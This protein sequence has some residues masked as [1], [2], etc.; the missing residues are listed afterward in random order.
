MSEENNRTVV[1]VIF[2]LTD[3][4]NDHLQAIY[5]DF[6]NN[7]LSVEGMASHYNLSIEDA[8]VLVTMAR[9]VHISRTE[10]N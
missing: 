7:F 3:S 4:T 5:L 6:W 10:G 9:N 8:R 2:A 1:D